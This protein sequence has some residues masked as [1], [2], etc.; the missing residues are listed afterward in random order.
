MRL[1]I[2]ARDEDPGSIVEAAIDD[3]ELRFTGCPRHPAD[4]T[5]DGLLDIFDFLAFQ[6]LFAAMDPKADFTGDGKFDLF[7]F[8]EFQNKFGGG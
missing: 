2:V 1:R 4:L 3:L 5:R 7:D 8:L 6:N